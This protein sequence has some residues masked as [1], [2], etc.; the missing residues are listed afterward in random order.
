MLWLNRS[1]PWYPTAAAQGDPD[2]MF[3]LAELHMKGDDM[4]MALLYYNKAAEMGHY[5]AL[6]PVCK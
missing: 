4:E 6:K 1:E 2:A 5:G 3:N